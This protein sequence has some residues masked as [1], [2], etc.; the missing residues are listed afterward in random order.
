M[1]VLQIH[2]PGVSLC[3]GLCCFGLSARGNGLALNPCNGK[4]GLYLFAL[5]G[6]NIS[7]REFLCMYFSNES[8]GFKCLQK[9]Q[10]YQDM[11]LRPESNAFI[12]LFYR[13]RNP[14][15]FLKITPGVSALCRF[16]RENQK[17]L[18]IR[19]GWRRSIFFIIS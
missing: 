3:P 18:F 7:A 12:D 11:R 16:L 6:Q 4:S 19:F 14:P 1:N 8:G 17:L 10:S 13:H 15:D 5:K 2:Y 9:L